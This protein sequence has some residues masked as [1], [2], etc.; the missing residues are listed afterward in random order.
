MSGL[1]HL[2]FKSWPGIFLSI[3]K[4]TIY[5]IFSQIKN[6]ANIRKCYF[7]MYWKTLTIFYILYI[8]RLL[9]F[10]ILINDIIYFRNDF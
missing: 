10:F 5:V 1:R 2:S 9:I 8:Q 4:F 3:S 7:E 6:C